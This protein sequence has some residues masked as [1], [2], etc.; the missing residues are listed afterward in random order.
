MG[1]YPSSGRLMLTLKQVEWFVLWWREIFYLL[2]FSR[3]I[4]SRSALGAGVRAAP[5]LG[6]KSE[7]H[8][9]ATT[10]GSTP[11]KRLN[12][13]TGKLEQVARSCYRIHRGISTTGA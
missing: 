12:K 1:K 10:T 5:Q 6:K 7:H 8:E 3:Q 9:V 11:P 13:E 4:I 2:I